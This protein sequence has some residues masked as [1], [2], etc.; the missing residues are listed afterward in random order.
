MEIVLEH[1]LD[2]LYNIPNLLVFVRDAWLWFWIGIGPLAVGIL[3]Q[4]FFVLLIFFA[5]KFF[6]KY[7]FSVAFD[8]FVEEMYK[9]FEEILWENT[10]TWIKTYIISLFFIILITNI[11][12]WLLDIVRVFFTDVEMLEHY[13]HL[14]TADFNF[15]VAIASISILMFLF[16]QFRKLKTLHFILEYLPINGKN[17]LVIERGKLPLLLYLPIQ[18]VVKILDIWISLFIWLLDIVG[19]AAKVISLSARLYG[20]MVAGGI[21][22]TILVVGVNSFTQT[23]INT[24]FPIIAPLI[25]YAQWLLVGVIQAFVFPLLVAIFIKIAQTEED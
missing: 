5:I 18:F 3:V 19:I 11:S 1:I 12:I 20:N 10:K 25:L 8:L 14:P 4:I 17:I 22:M 6:K 13:V 16:I 23:L 24:D 15:T 7:K 2:T 21:L 9:F